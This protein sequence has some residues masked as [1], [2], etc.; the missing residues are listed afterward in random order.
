MQKYLFDDIESLEKYYSSEF[1]D[2]K[3]IGLSSFLKKRDENRNLPDHYY[4]LEKEEFFRD[5]NTIADLFL[6]AIPK[7]ANE[8]L[9]IERQS[10]SVK[11]EKFF[12]WQE[13]ICHISPLVFVAHKLEPYLVEESNGNVLVNDFFY[14]YILTNTQN[15]IMP[16]PN[17]I[18]LDAKTKSWGG[19][20]DLHIHLNGTLE[21]DIV[22]QDLLSHPDRVYKELKKSFVNK[23]KVL[24]QLRQESF[25]LTPIKY[26]HLLKIAGRLRQYFFMYCKR[27]KLLSTFSSEECLLNEILSKN[28][29]LFDHNQVSHPFLDYILDGSEDYKYPHSIECLMYIL[30]LKELKKSKNLVLS[31]MFHFY[32]LILGLNNRLLVQQRHQKGFEQFQKITL[33]DIRRFSEST[34]FRR[35]HQLNGNNRNDLK[36]IEGRIAPKNN[37]KELQLLIKSI[38]EGWN[39]F[40]EFK[41]EGQSKDTTLKLIV[42]FIKTKED[43]SASW[44][45]RFEKLR[46]SLLAQAHVLKLYCAK[47]IDNKNI[48]IV[49]I[50]AASSEFDTPPEVFAPVFRIL[51]RAGIKSFTFHAGEDFH[52]ILSGIRAIYEAINFCEL[53]NGDRIGHAT[54]SGLSTKLWC[55]EV[56]EQIYIRKGDY[57]DDLVF[58]YHFI[59]SQHIEELKPNLP[60][61]ITKIQELAFDVYNNFYAIGVIEQAWLLRAAC[62]LH[63]EDEAYF[64]H[65]NFSSEEHTFSKNLNKKYRQ[66]EKIFKMYHT[67]DVKNNRDVVL[68]INPVEFF[69]APDLELIQKTLLRYMTKQ[70][71]VIETL[72]TSNVRI[73]IHK[74][75]S[76]Y[77][78]YNWI[79]WEKEGF[80]IPPIVIGTDDAGIFATNIYNEYA[81]VYLM[82]IQHHNFSHSE[83]IEIITKINDNSR[84][85]R[86]T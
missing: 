79:K 75:F 77:H 12:N 23:E 60:H 84:V 32:N 59:V 38:T 85:Y 2:I 4:R 76:T 53:K 45:F 86:F 80:S 58:V 42:H 51:R 1:P 70:E 64:L 21:T 71:I 67:I 44:V 83:A 68:D 40:T 61:L 16:R 22:W 50:D 14:S 24:E 26:T 7:I 52:H 72:P 65:G 62:P 9:S 34:Y 30:I 17:V 47:N 39:K 78:L 31:S 20:H 19:L 11:S 46:K 18:Q 66:A 3:D 15:T 28:H 35:F 8:F 37:E 55:N 41:E 13:Y 36:Y 56:G 5:V 54:A 33:N 48:S 25:L 6:V 73:G 82:L 29:N 57:L 74:D 27:S 10:I 49:G 69:S 81:S 43:L 63:M